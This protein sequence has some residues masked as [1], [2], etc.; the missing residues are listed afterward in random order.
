LTALSDD[1]VDVTSATLMHGLVGFLA[2]LLFFEAWT[3]ARRADLE[4]E[5][6][7][8]DLRRHHTFRVEH[9]VRWDDEMIDTAHPPCLRDATAAARTARRRRLPTLRK[10]PLVS[11]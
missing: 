8:G 7:Q 10:H 6:D 3:H 2:V 5:V 4:D 1:T 11:R 9:I